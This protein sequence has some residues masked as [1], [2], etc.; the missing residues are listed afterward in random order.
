MSLL[1]WNIILS[2]I[3]DLIEWLPFFIWLS[4]PT[5]Q[6][7]PYRKLGAYL[8]VNGLLKST[9]FILLTIYG[10]YN[11]MPFYHIM[12]YFEVVLLFLFFAEGLHIRQQWQKAILVY[13]LL[14]NLA[15]SL[16][17]QSI[18]EFNSNIW[19]LNTILLMALGLKYLYNYLSQ[20]GTIDLLK[21]SHFIILTALLL[22]FSGTLFLYIVSSE[23]LSKDAQ[24][25]FYNAWI[26]RSSADIIKCIL[27]SFGL[28]LA[29]YN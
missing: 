13:L 18:S 8:F 29:K 10:R 19:A 14:S 6:R 22:Y 21:S 23:V 26:I 9:T 11:T 25:F 5:S 15:N 17:F 2:H 4:L 3:S 16:F 12:A 28:C 27:L 24:G 1:D 7:S 20:I